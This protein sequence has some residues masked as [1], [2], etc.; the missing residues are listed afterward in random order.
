MKKVLLVNIGTVKESLEKYK[1]FKTPLALLKFSTYYKSKGFAVEIVDAGELA[2]DYPDIIC[3]SLIFAFLFKRY[4]SF[5][6]AYY[7]NYP[8]AKIRIGGPMVTTHCDRLKELFPGAEVHAGLLPAIE[9]MRPDYDLIGSN[10]SYGF[11]TRGCPNKCKW[12]IVPKCEGDL[13]VVKK[14]KNALGSQKLFYAMDNNVLAAGPEH[15]ES[16][17]HEMKLRGMKVDFNQAMDCRIFMRRKDEFGPLFK[18]Y[19]HQFDRM[20]FAWDSKA[21][22][23]YA[24][25]TI[26][27]LRSIG[28]RKRQSWYMLY[29]DRDTP[30][31]IHRRI[32]KILTGHTNIYVK[33]MLFID[34]ETGE[35]NGWNGLA[36]KFG[37]Y[38]AKCSPNGVLGEQS[39][40]VI[41][42]DVDEMLLKIDKFYRSKRMLKVQDHKKFEKQMRGKKNV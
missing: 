26:E 5:I 9:T 13:Y 41:G 39:Q 29:G 6:H 4:I 12:C 17:L 3:F 23:K 32:T 22:D 31:E 30:E 40:V 36:K 1:S 27:Y 16:V 21:Q 42:K 10:V 35:K 33:P 18:K 28:I 2:E 11:T 34:L 25:E 20:N 7:K 15:V 38:I 14:W 37:T 24:P 19:E 8:K